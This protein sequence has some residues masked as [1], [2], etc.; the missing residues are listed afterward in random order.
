M[1]PK[2]FFDNVA[3]M[4]AA[5]RRYFTSRSNYDLHEAKRLEKIIDDEIK[6][7]ES[8]TNNEPQQ[9]TLF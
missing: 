4:R 8:I 6:R 2:E 7:V 9:L 3:A 1:K 5:Q